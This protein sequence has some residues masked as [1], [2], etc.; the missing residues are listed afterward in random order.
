MSDVKWFA[1]F[2]LIVLAIL[3]VIGCIPI[4]QGPYDSGVTRTYSALLY[5]I[6][7]WEG[8]GGTVWIDKDGNSLG[9][10]P[11]GTVGFYFFPDNF[12]KL[13]ELEQIEFARQRKAAQ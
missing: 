7:V 1:R 4:P 3:F 2:I 8:P 13:S 6:V 9:G 11:D 10:I 5:K 12:K